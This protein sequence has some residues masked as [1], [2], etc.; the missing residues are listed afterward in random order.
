MIDFSS[1]DF[2]SDETFD[3]L[4]QGDIQVLARALTLIESRRRVDQE[5]RNR[6]LERCAQYLTTRI[7]HPTV[8]IAVTGSPGVGKSTLIDRLGLMLV[9]AEH[10]VAVLAIDP[11]SEMTGGS[12][13]GDKTRMS[14]LSG[15]SKAFIRPTPSS[16]QLGGVG[17]MT[18]ESIMVCEVAGFDRILVETVGVGQS[19]TSVAH[20]VDIVLLV[21]MEGSGD[22]LQGIKRGIL[23]SMDLVVVNKTDGD[24][25]QASKRFANELKQALHLLR[26][27]DDV[28]VTCL[29]AEFGSGI[30]EL[31]SLISSWCNSH[32][33]NGA[34]DK[35]RADQRLKWFDSAVARTIEQ[36]ASERTDLQ[37]LKTDLRNA[38]TDGNTTPLTAAAHFVNV[39]MDKT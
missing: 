28:E 16:G 29:S 39:L 9:E 20:L 13:L 19:E 1:I 18:R 10:T 35:R 8:R 33:E 27:H 17:A 12:I 4:T 25:V 26:P 11:S 23:E 22:G 31:L 34:F 24:R 7:A 37:S 14:G 38:I 36:I 32:L 30:S 5:I 6:F 15:H 21:T 3:L 2:S